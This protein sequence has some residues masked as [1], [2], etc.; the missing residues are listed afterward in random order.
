MQSGYAFL[1]FAS[2][3]EGLKSAITAVEQANNLVFDNIA[4]RCKVTHNLQGQLLSMNYSEEEPVGGAP[5]LPHVSTATLPDPLFQ[6]VSPTHR[7][8]PVEPF[9]MDSRPQHFISVSSYSGKDFRSSMDPSRMMGRTEPS[10]SPLPPTLDHDLTHFDV[11]TNS[12]SPLSKKNSYGYIMNSFT[13]QQSTMI[14]PNF[15]FNNNNSDSSPTS[16]QHMNSPY[17]HYHYHHQL[18]VEP[19]SFPLGNTKTKAKTNNNY[20]E[21]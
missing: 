17:D 18:A 3:R 14:S 15:I 9:E 6:N 11:E 5:S 13:R 1:H 12:Y 21:N 4:Y 8:N 16:Q 7:M 20:A 2:T 10:L 19:L